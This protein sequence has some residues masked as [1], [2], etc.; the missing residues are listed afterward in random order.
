MVGFGFCCWW[1]INSSHP[2]HAAIRLFSTTYG[3]PTFPPH[4]TIRSKLDFVPTE[5]KY[6]A[7]YDTIDYVPSSIHATSTFIPSWNKHFHAIELPVKG[8]LDL[9]RHAH[10]SLAYRFDRPFNVNE[11]EQAMQ[12][13]QGMTPLYYHDLECRVFDCHSPDLETW[14]NVIE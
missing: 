2:I 12:W 5:L 13:V 6:P 3:T 4:I 10:V 8:T 11:I 9:P 7:R 1:K 14:K